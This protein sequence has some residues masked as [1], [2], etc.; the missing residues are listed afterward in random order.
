[1]RQLE[2]RLSLRTHAG[3]EKPVVVDLFPAYDEDGGL[4]V[5]L[6]PA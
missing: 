1:M 5:A 3:L 6:T 4:L 2:Q